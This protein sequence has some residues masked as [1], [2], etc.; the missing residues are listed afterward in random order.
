MRTTFFL[1]IALAMTSISALAATDP[2]R[3]RAIVSNDGTVVV[4]ADVCAQV[5]GVP[6]VAGAAYVPGVD[7]EGKAV[8][9][10]DLPSPAPDMK[11][12]NLPVEININLQRR[13]GIPA[14]ARLFTPKAQAGVVTV[15]DG[16]AYF[17][18][19]PLVPAEQAA[20]QA[21]CAPAKR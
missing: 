11:L 17:N 4:A 19:Q 5:R 9:P 20:L 18:G 6:P 21:G 2:G 3:G 15:R 13:F 10:A 16:V 7:A 8:A 14:D 12:E 1:M